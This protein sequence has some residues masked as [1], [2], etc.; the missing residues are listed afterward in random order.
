M[1][2][3]LLTVTLAAAPVPRWPAVDPLADAVN[4]ALGLLLFWLALAAWRAGRRREAVGLPLTLVA[5]LCVAYA[6][7]YFDRALGI[8][9]LF[10]LDFSTHGAVRSTTCWPRRRSSAC[11]SPCWPRACAPWPVDA[12]VQRRRGTMP[13]PESLPAAP[14][15]PLP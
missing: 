2:P 1:R 4:P 12:P 10:G 6:L 11:P 9:G 8:F 5:M 14:P 15:R 7:A 3:D 13:A